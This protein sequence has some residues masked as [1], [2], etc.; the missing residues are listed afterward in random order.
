MNHKYLKMLVFAGMCLGASLYTKLQ[1]QNK[2]ETQKIRSSYNLTKLEI[3]RKKLRTE[4]TKQKQEALRLAKQKGWQTEI[5]K[6]D[7]G[8]MEIQ[9]VENGVPIYYTTH[10]VDAAK[11]TR[12]DHLHTGGSLGLNLLGQGMTINV[13]DGG[14]VQLTHEDYDGPGGNNR[15]S[16]ID[17]VTNRNA[18]T[19]HAMHVTGTLIGSGVYQSNAKGMA[20]HARAETADWNNDISEATSEA[21]SGMLIS[22]HSYGLYFRDPETGQV[23]LPQ[24]Y[25]GAYVTESRQWDQLMFN[26]PY[27]LMV[28]SAGNDGDDNTANNNPSGGYGFDKLT[29]ASTA[30]NNL[31]VANAQDASVDASGNLISVVINSGSSEGPTDD[32]RIKPD[33]TG[34]GTDVYSSFDFQSLAMNPGAPNMSDGNPNND[35]YSISGT[36]MSGPNVAGSLLLLQQHHKNLNNGDFMKAATLKGL[37]L[38]TADDAGAS[39][40]DAVFGWGLLNTKRAAETVTNKGNQSKIEELTLSSGQTYTITVQSDGT[41]PL[42]AS[43][44]WTDRPG[45]ATTSVNSTTPVLVNDLDI[46]VSKNGT[47]Y[48]P[49]K[50]TGA[51]TSAKQDNNVDPFERVDV[52]NAS[53]TYTITVTHKGSLVGG[54]QDYSLIVTGISGNTTACNATVPTGVS[55]SNVTASGVTVSWD[56]VPQATY[57]VRYRQVG[58]TTWTTV[59]VLST[60]TT[61]SGLSEGTQ[62]EVQVRS[63]CP[64][65]NS[66]Y[67][68][69]VNFTTQSTGPPSVQYCESRGNN[70]SE[71]HI[72][73]VQLGTI[74]K[75][76]G[77]TSGYSDFTSVSTD[78]E[79]STEYTI[80]I[81]PRW[82]GSVYSEGYAVFI[83]YNQDGD[84]SDPDETVWTKSPS[85]NTA[86]S[87]TFTVPASAKEGATR[88]RV[89][90]RYNAV[91]SA[92][93]VYD[94]GETEDYTVVI[95][96]SQSDTQAP[97]V[98]SNLTTSNITQTEVR[99]SWAASTDNI[100]VEGYYVYVDGNLVGTTTDTFMNVTGLNPNTTYTFT[101]VAFD[102]ANNESAPATVT[103]TTLS[104]V[105]NIAPS[106]PGNLTA[107]NITQTQVRLTWTASTDNIGVEGYYVYAN[108]NLVGTVTDTFMNVTGLNPNTTYTFTVVAFDAAGNE[109]APAT[110]TATTLSNAVS[111]CSSGGNN[112]NY[113]WIDYVA[114]G[115][116]TNSTGSDYGYGDY[117]NK[118]ATVGK[119]G[120][121]HLLFS[122]GFSATPYVEYWAAWIDYNQDGVF[123]ASERVSEGSSSSYDLLTTEVNIPYSATLGQTRM[124]VSMKWDGSQTACEIF[125]YGEVE[126]YTV[127]IVS[128]GGSSNGVFGNINAET[129]KNKVL[130]DIMVYPNPAESIVEIKGLSSLKGAP[131]AI[132]NT[133]GSVIEKGKLKSYLDVSNLES[134]VYILEVNDGQKL[135]TSKIVKK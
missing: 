3:L 24:Y 26:A 125:G 101:V 95:G 67:S 51:T 21:S 134:G 104:E 88:M 106:V 8:F 54:K 105:D 64:T 35:Y 112:A 9:R 66:N 36:S 37:A 60:S 82:T 33:I 29:A 92:C 46:R 130:S 108:G 2:Q 73:R 12:T 4:Q 97:S 41:S 62:Y 127:N 118:V 133:L 17:G 47:T 55:T 15:A 74:N 96:G 63:V 58:T 49:Y 30:K 119:G 18:N 65:G 13:W 39:G 114:F 50:L 7:G 70:S 32:F 27:Y 28:R 87:G 123:S 85:T 103:A 90:L 80:V 79:K 98:P 100:G 126:D 48:F 78:L 22:N 117:T 124:R 94:Y 77:G 84:F 16:V 6:K 71:E 20:P 115:G 42:L 129:L 122:A 135:L 40:P 19:F 76:S 57:Q 113:E 111:Y 83:D 10:N 59:P 69:S 120:T 109:S 23:V 75:T 68:S 91:P 53:G 61:L 45:T 1:A 107:S 128:N 99:L 56:T 131:Y 25:F 11:S 116:M 43:I 38:H 81:T 44:S 14:A 93:G 86:V 5:F 132:V 121:Y 110:T 102:A 89:I 72:Q 52:E 31:V 34:N